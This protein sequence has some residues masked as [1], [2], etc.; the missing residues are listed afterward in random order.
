MTNEKKSRF[1]IV[2]NAY[3]DSGDI[4]PVIANFDTDKDIFQQFAYIRFAYPENVTSLTFDGYI[5][6]SKELSTM[7]HFIF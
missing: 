2:S 4:I 3:S 5:L 7:A 1:Q 6:N